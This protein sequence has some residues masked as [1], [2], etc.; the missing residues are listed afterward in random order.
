[1]GVAESIKARCTAYSGL[2]ALVG[3]RVYPRIP[4]NPTFPLVTYTFV[5]TPANDY[6]D[7]DGTPDR[8]TYRVQFDA[9]AETV[10]AARTIGDQL[11]AAFAGWESGTAVG[12][13]FV[14]NRFNSW[15]PGYEKERETVEVVIDHKV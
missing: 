5:S 6:Q 4:A 7:H 9:Y 1:V 12:Y 3:T 13:S 14:D 15:E 8:W 2:S 10:S 11:F